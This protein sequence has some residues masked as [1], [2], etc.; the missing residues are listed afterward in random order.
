MRVPVAIRVMVPVVRR[1]P[2]VLERVMS[3][4]LFLAE[5]HK[6]GILVSLVDHLR[7]VGGWGGPWPVHR[8]SFLADA[9]LQQEE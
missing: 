7:T 2:I 9:R 1:R 4:L 3:P 5:D 8:T 6:S